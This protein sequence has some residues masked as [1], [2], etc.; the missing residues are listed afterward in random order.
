M[1]QTQGSTWLG[2]WH[3]CLY[4]WE[5]RF[6]A[7]SGGP[8]GLYRFDCTGGLLDEPDRQRRWFQFFPVQPPVR[9]GLNN[10]GIL[11]Q[12]G[13]CRGYQAC[14]S[15]SIRISTSAVVSSTTSCAVSL[16]RRGTTVLVAPRPE[17]GASK[18]ECPQPDRVPAFP[19][20]NWPR[21]ALLPVAELPDGWTTQEVSRRRDD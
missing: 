7:K 16:Q 21:A 6:S 14:S 4:A 1:F 18:Q 5:R 12:G 9:S 2:G 8:A 17:Q 19:T 3:S 11:G 20:R 13:I 10:Y 15:Y